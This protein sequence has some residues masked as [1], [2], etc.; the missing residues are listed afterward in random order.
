MRAYHSETARRIAHVVA[1]ILARQD[2]ARVRRLRVADGRND[3]GGI[4]WSTDPRPYCRD[5]N[6][7]ARCVRFEVLDD[8]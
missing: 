3:F 7:D 8:E 4:Y 1:V 5:I 6:P 2:A